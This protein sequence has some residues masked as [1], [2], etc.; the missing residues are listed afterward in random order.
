M[1]AREPPLTMD[2]LKTC[3]CFFHA[4]EAEGQGL[5]SLHAPEPGEV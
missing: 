2:D 5:R 4:G 1:E 3:S